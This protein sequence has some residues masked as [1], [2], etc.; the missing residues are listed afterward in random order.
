MVGKR[1][2]GVEIFDPL[3]VKKPGGGAFVRG[4]LRKRIVALGRRGKFLLL[5]LNSGRVWA[6]HLRMT[7]RMLFGSEG[8]PEPGK[9][10]RAI[11]TLSGGSHLWFWDTRRFGEWYL[12]GKPEEVPR[13]RGMGPEPLE[14]SREEFVQRVR[15]RNRQLKALLLD[16]TFLGGLGNIYVCEALYRAGIHPKRKADSLSLCNIKVLYDHIQAV[17]KE[18][19]QAGG[20]SVRSYRRSDGSEGRFALKL[21]VYGRDGK[22]CPRCGHRIKRIEV[23]GRGTFYCPGCQRSPNLRGSQ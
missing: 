8:R 23:S 12:V 20:S 6:A 14:I 3:L 18:A 1:I 22:R 21:R 15:Q 10:V 9:A 16:Q 7:G 11:L 4:L 13:I 19:I 17:L 5:F 2:E